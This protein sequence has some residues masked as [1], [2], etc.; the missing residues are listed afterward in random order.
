MSG[1]R[2][3]RVEFVA[4]LTTGVIGVN[5]TTVMPAPTGAVTHS[6]SLPSVH[7]SHNLARHKAESLF[8]TNQFD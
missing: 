1:I 2:L 4:S 5:E 3:A 6:T 8:R 7:S